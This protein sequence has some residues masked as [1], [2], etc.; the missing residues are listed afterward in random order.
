[1]H[2]SL[3]MFETFLKQI[4]LIKKQQQAYSLTQ[5]TSYYLKDVQ[6]ILEYSYFIYYTN[7]LHATETN[8]Y[9]SLH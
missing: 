3:L 5:N 1:M 7:T 6:R 2:I 8:A 4:Y 9:T